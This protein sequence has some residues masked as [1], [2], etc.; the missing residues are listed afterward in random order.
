MVGRKIGQAAGLERQLIV[1]KCASDSYRKRFR[2]CI[3]F[4]ETPPEVGGESRRDR[5]DVLPSR[6]CRTDIVQGCLPR[7][8]QKTVLCLCHDQPTI[9]LKSR[10][11]P[12]ET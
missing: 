6:A 7:N 9:R 12:V 5:T 11:Q 3:L 10:N 1:L 8:L 2:N 4:Y